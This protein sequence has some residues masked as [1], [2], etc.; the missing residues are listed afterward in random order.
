[1]INSLYLIPPNGNAYKDTRF[2]RLYIRGKTS[3][4][5]YYKSVTKEQVFIRQVLFASIDI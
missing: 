5:Q 4:L 1:M 2:G 3:L